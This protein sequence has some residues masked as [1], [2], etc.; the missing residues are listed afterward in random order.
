MFEMVS[1]TIQTLHQIKNDGRFKNWASK[2]LTSYYSFT[3]KGE[4]QSFEA[5]QN[6]FVLGKQDFYRHLQVR[7]YFNQTLKEA[8]MNSESE[9]L[10]VFI[11]FQICNMQQN[12]SEII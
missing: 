1:H 10:Q 8:L 7:H 9:F 11:I 3:H 6:K 5:L 4:F 12:Y 2:G